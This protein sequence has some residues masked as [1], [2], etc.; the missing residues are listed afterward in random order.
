M[1]IHKEGHK[2][3]LTAV[4]ILAALN[5]VVLILYEGGWILPS[6]V[7]LL[8]I[9]K[10]AFFLFFFRYPDR[11]ITNSD[12]SLLTSPADGKIVVIEETVEKEYLKKP[13][14]QISIFMSPLNIHSNLY[15]VSG[16]VREVIYHPGKYL[17]AWHPKSSELNERCTI[18]IETESGEEIVVRQI[19]GFVA[20]RIVTYARPGQKVKQ[21]DELGFIK[22]GSRVDL[23]TPLSFKTMVKPDL[24]VKGGLTVMGQI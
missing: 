16:T 18:V 11:I 3:I 13:T 12:Q 5:A 19:A 14:L 6:I 4:L 9:L 23:F 10:I 24:K 7:L 15:P 8:S 22:F 1:K 17:L 20:R 2:L 21:G